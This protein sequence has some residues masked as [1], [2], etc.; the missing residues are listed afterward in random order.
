MLTYSQ[1][2]KV[3]QYPPL[4]G[5]LLLSHR[6]IQSLDLDKKELVPSIATWRKKLAA[7]E[8]QQWPGMCL[9]GKHDAYVACRRHLGSRGMI[10]FCISDASYDLI[11]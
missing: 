5:L 10:Y 11:Q 7:N 2:F 3:L 1:A 8:V 6:R 4:I 9:D